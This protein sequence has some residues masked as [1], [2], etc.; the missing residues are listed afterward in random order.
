V[1]ALTCQLHIDEGANNDNRDAGKRGIKAKGHRG[2]E[3]NHLQV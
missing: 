3:E 2:N 1:I